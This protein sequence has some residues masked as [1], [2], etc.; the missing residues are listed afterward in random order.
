MSLP[1]LNTEFKRMASCTLGVGVAYGSVA[2]LDLQN[3]WG[4]HAWPVAKG[5]DFSGAFPGAAF[6]DLHRAVHNTLKKFSSE[7][8]LSGF[9]S[10]ALAGNVLYKSISDLFVPR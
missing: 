8:V 3:D 10:G 9:F 6:E 1:Q 5:L 4:L 7:V 2:Y